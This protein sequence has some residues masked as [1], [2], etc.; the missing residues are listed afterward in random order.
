MQWIRPS[1]G[2]RG[3]HIPRSHSCIDATVSIKLLFIK[4]LTATTIQARLPFCQEIGVDLGSRKPGL[5]R[6]SN[7]CGCVD[8][9]SLAAT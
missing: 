9:T 5:G 7:F 3:Y 4:L 6:F 1:L 2:G 8:V